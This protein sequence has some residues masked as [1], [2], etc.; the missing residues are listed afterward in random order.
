MPSLDAA[1]ECQYLGFQCHQL[2][3]QRALGDPAASQALPEH[4]LSR[5][6]L[7]A[8]DGSPEN[9]RETYEG[10]RCRAYGQL[11]LVNPKSGR[12]VARDDE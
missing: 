1:I 11:C 7:A 9:G 8:D 12:V 4:G 5:A 3:A 6:R 2:G 10:T